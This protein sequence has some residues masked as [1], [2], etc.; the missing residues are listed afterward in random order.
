MDS[1]DIK[2][3]HQNFGNYKRLSYKW[4]FALAEFVDN[5]TQSYAD[6]KPALDKA[7]KDGDDRFGVNITTDRDFIRISDNAMGM[8][9]L[10]LERSLIVGQ[11]P[12]NS[13]GR[14]R[15]GLGMKTAACWIGNKWKITTS[16]LGSNERLTIEIDVDD[17]VTGN[18]T[19]K[20]TTEKE[21]ESKHYTFIE[22]KEH[23]RPLKG[24]TIGKVKEYLRSI[25]RMDISSGILAL[26]YDDL[27][28]EWA[29]YGTDDFLT[30]KDGS[31]YKDDFIFDI[32]T[33]P[34]KKVA[35]GWVGVLKS[36]SRSKA[37]FSIFHRK[38]LI[39]GWP[40]S[41]RPEKIFGA[42]GRNDLIN[43]RVVG[44][45]NLEDFEVSHTKDEIN[46]HADEEDLVEEGLLEFC[47][48]YMEAATKARKGQYHG[49][50]PDQVHIDAAVRALEEE[51]NTQEFIEKLQ[52]DDALPTTEQLKVANHHVVDNAS[53]NEPSFIV[54]LG[55]MVIKVYLDTLGSPNDPYYSNEV[56][57]KSEIF[58]IVNIQHP[59]WSMLEGE[60]SVVN[61]LR[62]CVYDAVAE[63]RAAL[64]HRLEPDSIKR[65]KDGYLRVSFD[66]IQSSE[67]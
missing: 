48:P 62:H 63:H 59:H 67:N 43:Q 61:Y 53:A 11:P 7:F 31:P 30:R 8:N 52:L 21:D 13:K 26:K 25:Y 27:E 6:N 33:D 65:L 3:G 40:D 19:R 64:R 38:R 14:C 4:W 10:D 24:R 39:K 47:K 60:N 5:S 28:L 66:V 36:G 15:Y 54:S 17:V 32:N 1:I 18:I 51:L 20:L 41:W 45:I 37:G 58:V 50:G 46:W 42:G 16:K 55:D 22:I 9:S 35:V 2:F 44:E 49:Y 23:H 57:G 34:D 56:R 29:D 12:N